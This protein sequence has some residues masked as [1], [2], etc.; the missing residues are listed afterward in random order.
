MGPNLSCFQSKIYV[1]GKAKVTPNQF[2]NPVQ[3]FS[4][5]DDATNCG[6]TAHGLISF[7]RPNHQ[8]EPKFNSSYL[9]LENL[10]R[11]Q[12]KSVVMVTVTTKYT[13]TPKSCCARVET[14]TAIGHAFVVTKIGDDE[15]IHWDSGSSAQLQAGFPLRHAPMNF[16]TLKKVMLLD[17]LM[18]SMDAEAES[19]EP[20]FFWRKVLEQP[21]EIGTGTLECN[22]FIYNDYVNGIYARRFL[23]YVWAHSLASV[24]LYKYNKYIF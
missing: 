8:L 15:F 12:P 11:S 22:E 4:Y 9:L 13:V 19:N 7:L 23:L 21:G 18:P 16:N 1:L 20:C 10:W 3:I 5:S 17:Y 2:V 24:L 6:L 14:K